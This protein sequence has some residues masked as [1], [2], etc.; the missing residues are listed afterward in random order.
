MVR[1]A[2]S[3]ISPRLSLPI[4]KVTC[5]LVVPLAMVIWVGMVPVKS[6]A[7]AV[8]VKARLTVRWL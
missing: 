8:P 5:P 3:V 1:L 7:V 2:V 6:A 4:V